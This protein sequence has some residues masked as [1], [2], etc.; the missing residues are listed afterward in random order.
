MTHLSATDAVR[1]INNWNI[2]ISAQVGGLMA[3]FVHATYQ[4]QTCRQLSRRASDYEDEIT[5]N[6]SRYRET[7]RAKTALIID[8]EITEITRLKCE[9]FDYRLLFTTT[10]MV[11]KAAMNTKSGENLGSNWVVFDASHEP[12]NDR[13]EF[14]ATVCSYEPKDDL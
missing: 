11:K 14:L 8:T 9:K 3:K 4:A 2:C 13:I 7:Q 1:V 5:D 12:R 6:R 10:M